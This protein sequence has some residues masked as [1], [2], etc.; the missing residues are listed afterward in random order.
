MTFKQPVH[1]K[2]R[3]QLTYH[4]FDQWT[5]QQGYLKYKDKDKKEHWL[6]LKKQNSSRLV[7][8][9]AV[10]ICS[11]VPQAHF[12]QV[13]DVSFEHKEESIILIVGSTLDND[14]PITAS[15]GISNIQI[16]TV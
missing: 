3:V 13:V 8:L 6:W 14:D 10:A 5:G 4:Y 9:G 7:N 16:Y 15:Y 12:S 1:E 2:V 11:Q